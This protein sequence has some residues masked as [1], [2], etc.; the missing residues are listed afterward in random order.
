QALC[1]ST[2]Q[3]NHQALAIT[4]SRTQVS[5]KM[6]K[7]LTVQNRLSQHHNLLPKFN[8]QLSSIKSHPICL[9][10]SDDRQSPKLSQIVS[11]A[12]TFG[13]DPGNHNLG[14]DE[15]HTGD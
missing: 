4:S 14:K 2:E 10:L 8:R 6:I 3:M 15:C 12:D 7:R 5:L 13:L 1:D 11:P 9:N